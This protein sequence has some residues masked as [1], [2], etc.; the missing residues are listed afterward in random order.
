MKSF[1]ASLALICITILPL[2]AQPPA[3]KEQQDL[4]KQR[5][6]LKRELEDAQR[7]LDHNRKTTREN[8][9][10]LAVINRKLNIQE[11]MIANINREINL[12]DNNIYKSQRDINKLQLLLD[13]LKQEYAK[14]M[15]Y[16]YKNRSSSDFLNFIFSS[17]S[18]NDAIKRI[19]YLKSYRNYREMQGENILRTQVL[20]RTRIEELSGTKK[21]KNEV[22]QVQSREVANLQ[23][24]QDEKNKIV[25]KLKAEGKELN[26]QIAAKKQQM[27]T[28][29]KAIAAAIKRAIKEANDEKRRREVAE[30]NAAKASPT[31]GVSKPKRPE[32]EPAKKPESVLLA[33]EADV[34][35][36]ANFERN[37]GNLPWPVNS[38]YLLLH[39]GLNTLGNGVDVV[40]QGISIGCDI[41]TSVK[42]VFDG[43]VLLVNNYDDVQMVV[44]KHGRYFTGYSN[45]SGVSV[46][47]GQ[48]VK[49]GQAIGRAAAN[50]DGVGAVDF[51]I[52]NEKS[53]MNPEQWLKRR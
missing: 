40:S 29:N 33:T 43:E 41:G 36:N 18:F 50:L 44:I 53:E 14:S 49:V 28:V 2:S 9:S 39:Y 7:Q 23:T 11:N 32:K 8:M 51:Q 1:F 30:A 5:Q 46:S 26:K 20:L 35:L 4:E 47:K 24:Q 6:Q 3:T 15:V 42:A 19:S 16:A 17:H 25:A 12:M 38:G 22:L 34:T 37:R 27:Q 45:L 10:T 13:T 31:A 52:S 21:K 48:N